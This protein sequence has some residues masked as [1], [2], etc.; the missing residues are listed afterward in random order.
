[1]DS[2]APLPSAPLAPAAPPAHHGESLEGI[3]GTVPIPPPR[4]GFL[5]TWL[6][7]SGPALLVSVGYMDPG[8]WSTDL[9][10]GAEY[11]YALLWVVALSSLMAI[12]LQVCAAKLGVVTG[13]DLARASRDYAPRWT[14]WPNWLTTELAIAACDLAEVLGSAVAI[15]LLFPRIP[16]IFAV[17]I[18]SLDVLVL[19]TLQGMGF[20][21]IES[22]I[23]VLVSTIAGCYFIELFIFGH[24]Y[25]DASAIAASLVQPR[26]PDHRALVIGIGII[27]ATVMPHNLYLHSAMVQTRQLQKDDESVRRA[28]RYNALDSTVALSVAFLVNAAILILAATTF[29]GKT[30]LTFPGSNG[31]PVPIGNDWIQGAFHTLSPLMGAG[32]ASILF[33]VALLASGQSSTITGTLAGQ[34]VMEGFMS[35][36][37]RPWVRRLV[38]R[39]IAIL[40]AVVVIGYYGDQRVND[41]LNFSQVILGLQLPLAMIPLLIF[42]GSRKIMGPYTNSPP[43]KIAGWSSAVLI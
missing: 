23:L 12:I 35:W 5:R 11:R 14:R 41:L 27:G 43:L 18:T 7:F 4:A 33:A 40:P 1:M 15:H 37:I 6:A 8:N 16:L 20:R 21:K 3:R 2:S 13:K 9:S 39:L 31:Q 25:R 26:F 38:T 29:F 17:L 32:A 24:A 28:I 34:V 36:N 19:I 22:F 30:G 10:A 42:T